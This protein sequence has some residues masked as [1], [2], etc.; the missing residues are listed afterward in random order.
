MPVFR[1][2]LGLEGT[3]WNLSAALFDR[4][5]I[6]LESNPYKPVQGGIHPRE[7]AQHHASVMKELISSVVRDR[8]RSPVLLSPK[9]PGSAHVSGR[10]QRQP[11]QLLLLSMFLL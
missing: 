7:A 5:L 2:I 9:D 3:A 11:V 10:L 4:D 8:K 1:Q 6:A